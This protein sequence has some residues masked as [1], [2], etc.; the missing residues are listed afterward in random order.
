MVNIEAAYVINAFGQLVFAGLE[1]MPEPKPVK[2]KRK[3]RGRSKKCKN[4]I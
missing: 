4:M 3:K 1:K 2:K